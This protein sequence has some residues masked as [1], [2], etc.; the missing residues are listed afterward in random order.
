MNSLI[1]DLEK[2]I[3]KL[4]KRTEEE[5]KFLRSLF[6]VKKLRINTELVD[7]LVDKIE[8]HSIGKVVIHFKFKGE[9][10]H[11]K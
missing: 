6:K 11:A 2:K 5:N 8:V 7:A 1:A 4:E 9:D 3:V 10:F